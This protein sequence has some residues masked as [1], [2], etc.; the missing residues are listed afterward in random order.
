GGFLLTDRIAYD[1]SAHEIKRNLS[2]LD[3]LGV[4]ASGQ[5]APELYPSVT[6]REAVDRFL[7]GAG[8]GTEDTLVG[9]APGT[10]WNTKRWP[11]DRFADLA[12]KLLAE[13]LQVVVLGGRVDENLLTRYI[14]PGDGS[15]VINAAGKLSI[16]QSAELIGRCRILI[17]NDSAPMHLATAVRT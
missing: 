6:D 8:V 17:C 14:P 1:R 16:L 10:V 4:K 9:I 5:K 15:P 12:R 11:A 7:A 13:D 3:A 2:L